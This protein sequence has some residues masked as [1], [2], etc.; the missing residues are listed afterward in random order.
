MS[1]T[2]DLDPHA[3]PVVDPVV[4]DVYEVR[5]SANAGAISLRKTYTTRWTDAVIA[6]AALLCTGTGGAWDGAIC[7][8]EDS[9]REFVAGAGGCIAVPGAS[10]S[11]C[12]ASGGVWTDDDATAIG[13]YC[14]CGI[15]RYDDAAGRCA[16]I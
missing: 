2:I 13:S 16:D 9:T 6:T 4:T 10:E 11:G 14:V 5:P 7:T 8:C 12:D 3:G 1:E 15:G